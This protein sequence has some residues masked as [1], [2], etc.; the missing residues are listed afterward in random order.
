MQLMLG[1]ADGSASIG[2]ALVRLH[3]GIDDLLGQPMLRLHD[4]GAKGLVMRVGH[5]AVVNGHAKE[6]RRPIG[7][8]VR[9]DFFE[10]TTEPF[11]A[12]VDAKHGLEL[13]RRRRR[14]RFRS[15]VGDGVERARSKT[16]LISRMVDAAALD[17]IEGFDFVDQL[18]PL[19][20]RQ[21]MQR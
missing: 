5:A 2:P 1:R 17:A 9:A 6:P 15:M 12:R 19:R 7:S 10:M 18:G 21:C 14:D 20:C 16:A 8:H 4:N 3:K 13:R 11:F